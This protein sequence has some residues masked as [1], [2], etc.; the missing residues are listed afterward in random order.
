[1]RSRIFVINV[2]PI[3]YFSRVL[4]VVL[5][6]V[7]YRSWPLH[8]DE[9]TI[10]TLLERLY[11]LLV[12]TDASTSSRVLQIDNYEYITT[13]VEYYQMETRNLLR[14]WMLRVGDKL[15]LT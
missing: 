13:L 5:I 12:E 11:L 1:M 6:R 9:S 7:L 2:C 4:I 8:Q 10:N 14:V 15:I 3:I